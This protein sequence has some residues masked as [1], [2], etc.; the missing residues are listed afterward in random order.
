MSWT[1]YP[2]LRAQLRRLWER[3][4][5]LRSL[6]ASEGR[7][8]LRL[9]LKAPTST[10]VTERFDAVRD[11]LARL[12]A[13]PHVRI[14]WR[15]I[16][17]RVQGVQRLPQSIWIDD[18][19][20]ALAF[21]AKQGEADVFSRMLA[22]T[23]ERQP[24]LLSWLSKRPLQA[25]ELAP[26]WASLLK[27]VDW[28]T[29]HPR[30]G[31]YL[32]QIDIP[33]VHSKFIEAHRGVLSELFDLALSGE[34]INAAHSGMSGFAARYGFKSRPARIRFRLLD[35]RITLS[36]GL[37]LPDVTLD[38]DSF[39]RL[40]VPVRL[41][42]MTEN[43]TNFLAFPPAA[44]AM[45]VFGAGYG[46]DGLARAQ[47]LARCKIYYWGDID[48][49]GFAILDQLRNR[50]G[51]VESFL[52]DRDTLLGHRELWGEEASQS[53]HDLPRLTEQERALFDELRDNRLQRNLRLEQERIGFEQ[54][55]TVVN[56]LVA[57]ARSA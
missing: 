13:V 33:G 11:W 22:L 25:L 4:D 40:N 24:V 1:E 28:T 14:D 23:R 9:T 37:M 38:A 48:T 31:I 54:V 6:I 43:E 18:L 5:L 42:F 32:R 26:H 19:S 21:I 53:I 2:D 44:D 10:E 35:P 36:P 57:R 51:K 27:V 30:P 45:V 3:G 56:A 17:H 47:W 12:S 16:K 49:H 39:S 41:V 7:F 46:W 20:E 15:E 34:V 52:M 55:I 29:K 50:F 8:P